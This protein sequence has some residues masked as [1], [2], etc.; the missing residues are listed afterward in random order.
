M[1]SRDVQIYAQTIDPAAVNQIY[2]LAKQPAFDGSKIRIMPDAHPGKGCVIGFTAANWKS[3]MVNVVGVDIGCGMLTVE[4]PEK[5]IDLAK[6]DAVIQKVIPS[7]T[8]SRDD[9]I[10][11]PLMHHAEQI[12]NQLYIAKEFAPVEHFLYALGTLGGGN[13][14]IEIDE[15]ESGN[16]FLIIHSG[17]RTLGVRA[18]ARYQR[19]AVKDTITR[20][21]HSKE[22]ASQLLAEGRKLEVA[23]ALKK[24]KA[25]AAAVD[26]ETCYLS[27]EHCEMYLHDM[28]IIQEYAD[29]NRKMIAHVI[30]KH[31]GW[32]FNSL[33]SFTTVHNY[34]DFRDNVIRKGAISAHKGEKVLIPLNMR[35][36]CIIGY[37]KGNEDWNCSAPHGAGRLMSRAEAK[38]NIALDD[39]RDTMS[40]IYSSSVCES[41]IDESPF[42]Y[43]PSDEIIQAVADTVDIEKI[44]K[45]VYNYKAH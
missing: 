6:L 3:I 27:P 32:N 12:L 33:N 13:H 19:L 18:A 4:L 11:H 23:D 44:I 15:D 37:G 24:H 28:K 34:I 42:A 22:I 17:S 39:F 5:D 30:C 26:P 35:D 36:G 25:Q 31:M 41:T 40:G 1:A 20:R 29:I 43:K 8:N 2:N 10:K 21:D 16:K 14:F 7:G 45:P 38:Y 9:I